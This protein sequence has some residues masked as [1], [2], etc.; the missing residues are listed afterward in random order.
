MMSSMACRLD[1]GSGY[2]AL[3][4]WKSCD[5]TSNPMLDYYYLNGRITCNDETFDY[6]RC[7]N[8]IH[9]VPNFLELSVE[10]YRSLKLGGKLII[11]DCNKENYRKNTI[12]DTVWYRYI[13]DRGSDIEIFPKYRDYFRVFSDSFELISRKSYNEKEVSL[14]QKVLT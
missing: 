2:D 10:F 13:F 14:W 4:N 8:V 5:I 9:H 11:I 7:R 1:F 12:L 3:K 6:I